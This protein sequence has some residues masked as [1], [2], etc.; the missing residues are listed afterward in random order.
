MKKSHAS[1]LAAA[2]LSAAFFLPAVQAQPFPGGPGRA[3]NPQA[4]RARAERIAE[5]LGLTDAQKTQLKQ[6]HR[7][8]RDAME[9]LQDDESLT[10]KQFR[11]QMTALRK[12]FEEQR[13]AVL[14]PEQQ[15]KADEMRAKM[16]ERMKERRPNRHGRGQGPD[17]GGN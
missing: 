2:V 17:G 5:H 1:L 11:E 3:G 16:K 14:T 9:K 15:A 8:H 12:S 4:Q 13:R 10:R 6:L 7:A